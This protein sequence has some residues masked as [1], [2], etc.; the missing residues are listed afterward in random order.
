MKE[1]NGSQISFR[2]PWIFVKYSFCVY[3]Y[4]GRTGPVGLHGLK[5]GFI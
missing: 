5:R 3:R 2:R 1:R 4:T